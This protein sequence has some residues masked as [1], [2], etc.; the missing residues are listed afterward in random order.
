MHSQLKWLITD[1]SINSTLASSN[2]T[3][4]P[5]AQIQQ[6]NQDTGSGSICCKTTSAL[7]DQI[8]GSDGTTTNGKITIIDGT[9]K[10]H[11]LEFENLIENINYNP[12]D[13]FMYVSTKDP[14]RVSLLNGTYILD[15]M[16]ISGNPKQILFTH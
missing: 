11:S 1:S 6:F 3:I 15:Q 13:R 4:Q 7:S 8:I 5:V 10:V 2:A 9:K 14:G 12:L 16:E